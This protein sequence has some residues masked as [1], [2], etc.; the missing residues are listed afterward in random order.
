MNLQTGGLLSQRD[1]AITQHWKRMQFIHWTE[2]LASPSRKAE[3]RRKCEFGEPEVSA[4]PTAS[5]THAFEKFVQLPLLCFLS[6]K[7]SKVR[8]ALQGGCK[9]WIQNVRHPAQPWRPGAHRWHH[10]KGLQHFNYLKLSWLRSELQGVQETLD[11]QW[12]EA[13]CLSCRCFKRMRRRW[14]QRSRGDENEGMWP[15]LDL[16]ATLTSRLSFS[17]SLV[18]L[19]GPGG[20]LL[21]DGSQKQYPNGQKREPCFASLQ[22][23]QCCFK[24]WHLYSD[25]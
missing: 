7:M 5:C 22:S 2:I 13:P 8:P 17:C 12:E 4:W 18:L 9:D 25:I 20:R 3:G 19:S 10:L 15:S 1:E 24:T 21:R 14:Q 23:L 16:G 6:Y 11:S